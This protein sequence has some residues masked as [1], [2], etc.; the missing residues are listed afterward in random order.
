MRITRTAASLS[1]ALLVAGSAANAAPKGHGRTPVPLK[2]ARLIIE[3]NATDLDT[4]FQAF[5]D[6]E[7]WDRIELTGPRGAQLEFRAV[8][9]LGELGLTELFFESVEPGNAD[10]PI[11]EL[12]EDLPAGTYTFKGHTMAD[13]ESDGETIGTAELSHLIPAGPQ[14]QFPAEGSSVPGE[15]LVVRWGAV[16]KSIRAEPV[17]IV[18]YQIILER[19]VPQ[20]P[21]M[22]GKW[23]IDA[24]VPTNVTSM[25]V[26]AEF[27]E[28]NTA[29]KWEV[30]AIEKCGNQTLS[31]GAFRTR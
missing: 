21:R 19:D 18:A 1:L 22:I 20:H 28:P 4:G 2:T 25:T 24:I 5:V 8:G 12:F 3:H 23:R 30:L 31:S 6:S 14:L 11:A 29:Y 9:P 26:P 13:G 17:E 15:G 7:G 27:M 10:K 16:T